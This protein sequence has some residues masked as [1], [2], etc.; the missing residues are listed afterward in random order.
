MTQ[1][2][3]NFNSEVTS[4]GVPWGIDMDLGVGAGQDT[5]DMSSVIFR[6]HEF[7]HSLSL[8]E[9]CAQWAEILLKRT[10]VQRA[11]TYIYHKV[12]RGVT[13]T[14]KRYKSTLT[15]EWATHP[16]VNFLKVL[17][18][19]GSQRGQALSQPTRGDRPPV[20]HRPNTGT[21]TFRPTVV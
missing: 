14:K 10:K 15:T 19:R 18:S 7:A 21:L 12:K 1:G 6:K 2:K 17:S 8:L 13:S 9:D 20:H 16:F 11:L 3:S 4:C 5:G